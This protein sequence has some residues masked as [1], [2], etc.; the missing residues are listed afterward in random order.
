[1]VPPC[2][3]IV[4]CGHSGSL[5][6]R[7]ARLVRDALASPAVVR[8]GSAN[9]VRLK[10]N[11]TTITHHAPDILALHRVASSPAGVANEVVYLLMMQDPRDLL[12]ERD[13]EGRFVRS[14]DRALR[15]SA[16]GIPTF[17]DPGLLLVQRSMRKASRSYS[18]AL[19]IR[20]EDVEV[21]PA[22]VEAA[23]A[24]MTGLTFSRSFAKLTG[25]TPEWVEARGLMGD[26]MPILDKAA[27]AR[28][29]R[30]FRLAPELFEVVEQTG[31]AREGQHLWFKH[32]AAKYPQGLDDTPGLIVGFFTEG[33]R[34]EAEA[35]RLANSVEALG[36]P[37]HLE[38]IPPIDDWLTAVRRKPIV[39][40]ELRERFHG[41]LLYVDVD[42]V[43]HSDPWPYLRGYDGDMAVAGH[44]DEQ[45]ISGTILLNETPGTVKL[46]DA[47]IEAQSADPAAWDQHALQTV[48]LSDQADKGYRVD[49]LPPEMCKVFDRRYNPPVEA[50]IEHLQASR[51]RNADS[52]DDK[53][54]AQLAR[55]H[56][57]IAE[58]EGGLPIGAIAPSS[59]SS[60][61]S[62][63]RF[64]DLPQSERQLSTE[65]LVADGASDVKQ[66]ADPRNLNANWSPRAALVAKLLAPGDTVLDL[67]CGQMD[68]E[69]E[70]PEG[71]R[72]IP[73][74]IVS[75][76]KRTLYCEL[77]LGIFPDLPAD[78]VTMLGVLEY[79]H[80]PAAVLRAIAARWQKLVLTY[81]PTDLDAGRDR[82]LH[83]WFN[84]LTSAE[85]VKLATDQSYQLEAI[86][87][88]GSRERVY[89]FTKAVR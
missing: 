85:L 29:V 24:G 50:I 31:Y 66:W 79:C 17:S 56:A 59:P 62:D 44:R 61:L 7:F 27:A 1:M 57:R 87:P 9:Q 12:I 68:L 19:L 26:E 33:T 35:R 49:F 78:V 64:G 75:R 2:Q 46:I 77:N 86:V 22:L 13:D 69:R 70:L 16:E 15:I 11:C 41:P 72:Y 38:K 14:F 71:S 53:L 5:A 76:D 23:I 18:R 43:V 89:V 34:Y 40:R 54:V 83:G 36:L 30:Q 28:L 37:I 10:P 42:A 3:Q 21:R 65:S 88:H 39:L 63:P 52:D 67:G 73:A 84:S 51:E 20:Q 81:N 6:E 82:R 48:A 25:R 47:W 32:L 8:K 60:S 4:I 55:R 80:K 58:I 45:I 74:D